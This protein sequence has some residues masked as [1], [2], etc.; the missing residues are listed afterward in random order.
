ML[1]PLSLAAGTLP[2]F[3]PDRVAEAAGEAGFSHVGFTIEPER[4][5]AAMARRTKDA[6]ANH[7][8]S[9]LDVEVVWIPEGG[10]VI[11]DHRAIIDAGAEL[12]AANVLVVSSEP[13]TACTAEALHSLCEHAAPANMRVAIEFLMIT[14]IRSL[15]QALAVIAACDHPAA[16]I[17]IDT[18]HFRRAG[19]AP[20]ALAA[21]D[22]AL[23]PYAQFCDGPAD[24]ADNFESYMTDALDLR[25]APGEGDLP[26]ADILGHLPDAIPLSLE[27]RSKVYRDRHPDPAARAKAVR[28]AS[29]AWFA[30]NG[31]SV[32]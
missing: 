12:G 6:I 4:W 5:D 9:V 24:C 13:D 14:A 10:G 25:S 28:E 31:L 20:D 27:I 16:A 2:E 26:L 11:D 8:L 29:L 17:L 21:V 30:K 32:A 19:H 22:S 15:D 23:L 18:I 1:H 7:G 3:G